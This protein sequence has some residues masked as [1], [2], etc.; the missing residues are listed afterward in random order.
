MLKEMKFLFIFFLLLTVAFCQYESDS[1]DS[2][3]ESSSG[4]SEEVQKPQCAGN[5]VYLARGPGP[6][7]Y[8]TCW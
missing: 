5:E 1:G 3:S 4:E 7:C 2:D 6:F 8:P